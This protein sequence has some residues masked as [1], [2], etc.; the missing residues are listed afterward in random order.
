MSLNV[1]LDRLFKPR[2]IAIVGASSNLDSISGRP[3]KLLMR[4]K[5]KGGIFPVNPKYDSLH[6]FTCYPDVRS[7]PVSPDVVIV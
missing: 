4:Y 7:L 1:G 2:N 3:L 5:Y 6:G